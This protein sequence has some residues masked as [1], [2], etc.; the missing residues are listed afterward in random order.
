MT[1]IEDEHFVI[2]I[3]GEICVPHTVFL[4]YPKQERETFFL[5]LIRRIKK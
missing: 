4:E 2:E 1:S 3:W 5:K